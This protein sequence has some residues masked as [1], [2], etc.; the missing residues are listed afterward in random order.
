[1]DQ[2]S[3]FDLTE[4]EIEARAALTPNEKSAVDAFLAAA[5]ALPKSIC[6]AVDD[7]DWATLRVSKRITKGAAQ[8]VAALRKK[9][10]CF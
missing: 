10:L 9:S 4:E 2:K 5:R 6:V 1:M 3:Y 7:H 8:Q